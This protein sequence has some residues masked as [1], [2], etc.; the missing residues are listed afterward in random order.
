M[1]IRPEYSRRKPPLLPSVGIHGSYT[2][3]TSSLC[4]IRLS[5]YKVPSFPR[6]RVGT[7]IDFVKQTVPKTRIFIG[8]LSE[9]SY[10]LF[11]G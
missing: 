4:L 6:T 10:F 7:E 11:D 1:T 2:H 3:G 8:D 9:S 5:K